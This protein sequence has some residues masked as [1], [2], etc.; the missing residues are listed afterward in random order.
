MTLI[1]TSRGSGPHHIP[2]DEELAKL[3][4]PVVRSL[5][6]TGVFGDLEHVP[7]QRIAEAFT[8]LSGD[9]NSGR[10]AALIALMGDAPRGDVA[11]AVGAI[12]KNLMRQTVDLTALRG[13]LIDKPYPHD[14]GVLDANPDGTPNRGEFE[15]L[16]GFCKDFTPA[17]GGASEPGL[18]KEAVDRLIAANIDRKPGNPVGS[19]I[20]KAIAAGEF[21]PLLT[22][23][24][25]T[26]NDGSKYVPLSAL[27][28]LYLHSTLPPAFEARIEALQKMHGG[29]L[30]DIAEAALKASPAAAGVEAAT[31]SSPNTAPS[32][33]RALTGVCPFMS[34]LPG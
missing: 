23:F 32:L 2:T 30:K 26:A 9:P 8:A 15:R 6:K 33:L 3:P 25:E 20:D 34:R 12:V 27:E 4:C 14:T 22:V 31:G 24:G 17:S 1:N 21:N 5:A 18:D 10:L 28:S 13:S 29:S 16:K 11:T 19:K 7:S